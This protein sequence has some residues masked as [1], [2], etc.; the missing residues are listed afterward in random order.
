MTRPLPPDRGP[1]EDYIT[2]VQL[3]AELGLDR[4]HTRECMLQSGIRPRK[5]W[6][7]RTNRLSLVLTHEE[8]E[9][10]RARQRGEACC[11]PNGKADGLG[12]FF[13][14]GLVP[15][16]DPNRV[17]VGFAY[18]VSARLSHLRTGAPT[19]VLL[20]SWSCKP[21]WQGAVLDGLT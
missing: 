17:K 11:E 5:V 10:I 13:V 12:V 2:L 15:D 7:S 20:R 4:T 16:L 1:M 3:A 9:R 21:A 8:A 19:A 6:L 14:I 18:D